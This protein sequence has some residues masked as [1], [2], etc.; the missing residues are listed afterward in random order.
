MGSFVMPIYSRMCMVSLY[1]FIH[2]LLPHIFFCRALTLSVM[3]CVHT[4]PHL[5]SVMRLC[6]L[7]QL[8]VLITSTTTNS[9]FFLSFFFFTIHSTESIAQLLLL[10]LF[11][12]SASP[13]NMA[14][15]GAGGRRAARSAD[16]TRGS[17]AEQRQLAEMG[18]HPWA[19]LHSPV[20]RSEDLGVGLGVGFLW[21]F[22]FVL[23]FLLLF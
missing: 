8:H 17:L 12:C 13:R 16:P 19:T 6:L 15:N 10:S 1:V 3:R 5:N 21:G 7:R 22:F 4:H 14:N 11:S 9:T 23:I 2:N 20:E 18:S